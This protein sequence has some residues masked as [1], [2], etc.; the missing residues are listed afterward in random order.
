MKKLNYVTLEIILIFIKEDLNMF[1]KK[2]I[3][4][5]LISVFVGI[6]IFIVSLCFLDKYINNKIQNQIKI[7]ME[8]I[9]SQN[10]KLIQN[11]INNKFNLLSDL[12]KWFTDYK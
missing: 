3:S 11:E 10:I 7:S 6:G 9:S 2:G 12:S 8:D 5:S 1:E 4:K